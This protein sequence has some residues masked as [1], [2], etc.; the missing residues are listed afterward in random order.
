TAIKHHVL[1]FFS[2]Q[3][4]RDRLADT[5][6]RLAIRGRFFPGQIFLQSRNRGQRFAGIVI[7]HLRV[8][9]TCGKMDSET[10]PFCCSTHFFPDA[11]VNTLARGL[12][13]RRHF[14]APSCLPCAE[15]ARP[16]SA[17]LFPCSAR[18]DNICEYQRRPDR[19]VSYRSHI[20]LAWYS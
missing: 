15:S 4:L 16:H 1:H 20:S 12:S 13:I 5:F 3:L 2:Q 19:P 7:N 9:M 18:P 8:N 11:L 14:T 17:R 10:R 6:C